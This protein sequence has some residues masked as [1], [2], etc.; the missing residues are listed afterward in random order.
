MAKVYRVCLGIIT[1]L[2]LCKY[3]LAEWNVTEKPANHTVSDCHH[4]GDRENCTVDTEDTDEW[5]GHFSKCPKELTH[6]C[7]H[8]DCRYVT[9]QKTPSCRCMYGYHGT[10]CEYVDLGWLIEER[11]YIIIVATIAGLVL[12]TLLIVFICFCSHR[13]CRLCWRRRRR[14]EEPINGTEK[15][16][17]MD[18]GA[19][20]TTLDAT[21]APQTNT[22]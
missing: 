1:A 12:L 13:R 5:G 16:S 9:D 11:R 7:I 8:G 14:R 15:H 3:S 19:A 21:E 10:R 17:M 18:T 20:H 2:A 4:H 6:Y 22:V